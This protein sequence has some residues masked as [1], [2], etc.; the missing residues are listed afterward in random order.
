MGQYLVLQLDKKQM[1]IPIAELP[2]AQQAPPRVR[3]VDLRGVEEEVQL[4]PT[5][6][7]V[8]AELQLLF[9]GHPRARIL[10]RTDKSGDRLLLVVEPQMALWAE[11]P[12]P[13]TLKRIKSEAH[14]KRR[15]GDEFFATLAADKAN[16][17]ALENWL[18]NARG[19]PLD[20][21]KRGKARYEALE[22][23]VHQREGQVETVRKDVQEIDAL[24]HLAG[25]LHAQA[26]L[27]FEVVDVD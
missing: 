1:K 18:N 24:E 16:R 23:S 20:A 9:P 11:Q 17:T 12:M 13:F 27:W 5:D 15:A 19:I 25:Q 21:Y 6:G 7:V 10:V 26:K 3:V 4:V 2:D 22:S 14:Q 8:G